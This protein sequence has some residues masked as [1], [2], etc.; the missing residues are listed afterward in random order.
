MH[1]Q[2]PLTP[3]EQRDF[4]QIQQRLTAEFSPTRPHRGTAVLSAVAVI[5]C[6]LAWAGAMMLT[7]SGVVGGVVIIAGAALLTAV[8]VVRISPGLFRKP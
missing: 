2:S 1:E 5:G 8:A 7:A 4:R 6:S 3:Q